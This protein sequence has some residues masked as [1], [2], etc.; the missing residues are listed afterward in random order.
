MFKNA[1]TRS[2]IRSALKIVGGAAVT[3]FG[4]EATDVSTVVDQVGV[5]VG[6]AST[7]YGIYLSWKDKRDAQ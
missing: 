4:L 7:I 6:A 1:Q 3:Y 2:L 5:I